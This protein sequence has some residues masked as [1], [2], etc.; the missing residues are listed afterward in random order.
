MKRLAIFTSSIMIATALF[1]VACKKDSP[2][3]NLPVLKLHPVNVTGK[4]GQKLLDTLDIVAP[5][6]VGKLLISKTINLV[7]DDNFGVQT[8]TPVNTGT[9]TY[10]YIFEYT[11]QPDEVNKLVG[12]NY[13]FEDAQGNA[14]EKD[15]T[16]NTNPSAAQIIA[17]HKW[18]LISK[19][20]TTAT[21]PSESENDCERDNIFSYVFAD[22]TMSVD[23][24]A[25]G[26]TF[27]GFNIYEKWWVSDDEKTFTDVYHSVFNT[28]Q[29]TTE[30]YNI[31]SLSNDKWVMDIAYDLSVFGLSDH[32]VF[33]FT[34]QAQ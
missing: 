32:E 22:S 19:M 14:A 1:V 10:Q 5:N 16:I 20:W 31:Q 4:A 17:S 27:D 21:P 7:P 34:Y 23:Y 13:H 3:P 29:K 9:N 6:G 18:K 11:Y 15:L 33:V 8:V 30:V 2:D 24:G 28:E 26:C 25:M 12:I